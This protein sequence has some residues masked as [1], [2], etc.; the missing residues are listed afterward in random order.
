MKLVRVKAIAKKEFIQ[1]WRDPFSLAMALLMPAMLLFIFAYAISFD[2]DNISTAVYDQ[3]KSSLSRALVSQFTESRYF[4]LVA[5]LESVDEVDAMLDGGRA[6]LAI[7]IPHDFS[8]ALYSG[9]DTEVGIFL[10]GTDSNTA[11]VA[12]GYIAAIAD[13]FNRTLA[14]VR[15]TP[16]IDIRNRVWYNTELRSR[17]FIIPGLIAVIMSVIIS[18]LTS[19]TI[20]REWDRG[21]MEQLISTPV[22]PPELILGK[23]I[24]YFAVGLADT[25]ISI[26]LSTLFFG[27]P[28][29]GSIVLLLFLSSLFLFGGLSFGILVSIIGRNQLIASQ[30]AMLTSFLPAFMLSGF[31]FAIS[32]MPKPLQ[33]ITYIIPARY[34]VTILKAIYLKGSP[35]GLLMTEVLLLGLFSVGV[36]VVANRKFRKRVQ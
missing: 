28:L 11:N 9:K 8:E 2:V 22:K 15:I 5:N 24:P 35:L 32:N 1:I 20:A 36:F 21:T 6:K 27:V 3:D 10:D 30:L 34:F 16:L 18:L 29:R 17:N 12:Q 4:D 25:L 19:L 7:V 26:L 13:R 33:V 31:V 23:L 14:P